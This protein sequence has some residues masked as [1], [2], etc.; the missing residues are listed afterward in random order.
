MF[1]HDRGSVRDPGSS[2]RGA[3]LERTYGCLS[4]WRVRMLADPGLSGPSRAMLERVRDLY[5]R[6]AGVFI[7]DDVEYASNCLMVSFLAEALEIHLY[8]GGFGRLWR[9]DL[10]PNGIT[11]FYGYDKY[12]HRQVCSR[13]MLEDP[14]ALLVKLETCKK[15]LLCVL[16]G[17]PFVHPSFTY[18]NMCSSCL[19]ET[20]HGVEFMEI[21]LTDV[22]CGHYCFVHPAHVSPPELGEQEKRLDSMD[23]AQA[24]STVHGGVSLMADDAMEDLQAGRKNVL[25]IK[26]ARE[27]Q[28]A[29]KADNV[30]QHAFRTQNMNVLIECARAANK[31]RK[32]LARARDLKDQLGKLRASLK[33]Q[34][35]P[36]YMHEVPLYKWYLAYASLIDLS[37]LKRDFIVRPSR[38]NVHETLPDSHLY[39]L[40]GSRVTVKRAHEYLGYATATDPA[41]SAGV[42]KQAGIM[43]NVSTRSLRVSVYNEYL[44]TIVPPIVKLNLNGYIVPRYG[45]FKY[46]ESMQFSPG[47]LTQ[48]RHHLNA[49]I[50]LKDILGCT[51]EQGRKLIGANTLGWQYYWLYANLEA[52]RIM[53]K[54]AGHRV[55]GNPLGISTRSTS[56][57]KYFL[58]FGITHVALKLK[59]V[60]V[61]EPIQNLYRLFLCWER[62]VDD[63]EDDTST[64]TT[65]HT[66]AASESASSV[67]SSSTTTTHDDDAPSASQIHYTQAAHSTTTAAATTASSAAAVLP[68]EPDD[69]EF[70]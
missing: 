4:V 70:Y 50:D 15:F 29:K 67:H 53:H 58:V 23:G 6:E 35:A 9:A 13:Y 31:I 19:M 44:N 52:Y 65:V 16:M 28:S 42:I 45:F 55:G 47:Q 10:A 26:S 61:I 66:E 25:D 69:S 3:R 20:E 59:H 54:L 1:S 18:L 36:K 46:Y 30:E 40:R 41:L 38:I 12:F 57:A 48:H 14:D 49:N 32:T 60:F 27:A 37:R 51:F 22:I 43:K 8:S 62:D 56:L 11:S 5:W 33:E 39:T 68:E 34:E 24:A 21:R 17:G 7:K 2:D 64:T 63:D